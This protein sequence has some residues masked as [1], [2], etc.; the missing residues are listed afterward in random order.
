MSDDWV[1]QQEVLVQKFVDG[2]SWA[3]VV[4]S[5]LSRI[6]ELSVSLNPLFSRIEIYD[7]AAPVG[8]DRELSWWP[9]S[10]VPKMH[11]RLQ[12]HMSMFP[13]T[14]GP[15]HPNYFHARCGELETVRMLWEGRGT[16]SKC[17]L[18]EAEPMTVGDWYD[19]SQTIDN[20]YRLSVS[21][22]G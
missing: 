13:G 2:W 8:R 17:K 14:V 12:D 11:L 10:L 19:K 22:T 5:W 15:V 3:Q 7:P 16:S 20:G 1:R 18:G 21:Y 6:S 9:A 4:S